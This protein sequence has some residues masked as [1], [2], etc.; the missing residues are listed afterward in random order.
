[1]SSN[2]R[3]PIQSSAAT[4]ESAETSYV[5]PTKGGPTGEAPAGGSGA[6]LARRIIRH[7]S[8]QK[9]KSTDVDVPLPRATQYGQILIRLLVTVHYRQSVVSYMRE[10]A[11][12]PQC[13]TL[14]T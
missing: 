1:M 7:R 8:S 12:D 6:P 3:P 2:I 9:K 13:P 4:N 10:E 11:T 14:S 5:D